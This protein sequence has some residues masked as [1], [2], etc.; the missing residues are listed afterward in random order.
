MTRSFTEEWN[1]YWGREGHARG[2]L[3]LKIRIGGQADVLDRRQLGRFLLHQQHLR[4]AQGGIPDSVNYLPGRVQQAEGDRALDLH[5][6]S[7]STRQGHAFQI[8]DTCAGMLEQQLEPSGDGA[9]RQLKLAN[10]G[11]PQPH[12]PGYRKH[13]RPIRHPARR[14][15]PFTAQ[16]RRDRIHQ[17]ASANPARRRIPDHGRL[18]ASIHQRDA[19]HRAS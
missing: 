4:S 1:E 5:I 10:I 15:D 11:L 7:E 8:L 12:R 16:T 3:F 2:E 19:R 14:K 17:A 6:V 18:H 9:F 13:F